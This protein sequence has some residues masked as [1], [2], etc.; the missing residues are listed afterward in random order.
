MGT[1]GRNIEKSDKKTAQ[2]LNKFGMWSGWAPALLLQDVE[3]GKLEGVICY[4]RDPDLSWG[5]Q[6]AITEAIEKI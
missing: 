1:W 6:A 2:K 5:N 4:F 3:A